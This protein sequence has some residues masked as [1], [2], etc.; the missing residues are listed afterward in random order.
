[1]QISDVSEGVLY[2]SVYGNS[3]LNSW[4]APSKQDIEFN[5]SKGIEFSTRVII[6]TR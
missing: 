1:M 5:Q 6:N 2:D 3:G 4:N